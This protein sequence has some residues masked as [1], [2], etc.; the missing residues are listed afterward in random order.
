M[1]EGAERRGFQAE[2]QAGIRGG[3]RA[4]VLRS[5]AEGKQG[6]PAEQK[7]PL[8]GCGE[9]A[10]LRR[11]ETVKQR[12]FRRFVVGFGWFRGCR[13]WGDSVARKVRTFIS[14]TPRAPL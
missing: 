5:K 12:V 14:F 11:F 7:P 9:E 8:S 6:A 4:A 1:G 10:C 3:M 13:T 2:G